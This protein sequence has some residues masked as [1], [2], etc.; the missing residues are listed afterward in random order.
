M[1]IAQVRNDEGGVSHP[2]N[3]GNIECGLEIT[4]QTIMNIQKQYL[5]GLNHAYRNDRR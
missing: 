5:R 2:R 1:L 4:G 3:D